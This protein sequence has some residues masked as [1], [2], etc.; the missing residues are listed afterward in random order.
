MNGL[1]MP[2]V[3]APGTGLA[4][5]YS[6]G[7]SG[8][9]SVCADVAEQP[10]QPRELALVDADRG[11]EEDQPHGALVEQAGHRLEQRVEALELAQRDQGTPVGGVLPR[12]GADVGQGDPGAGRLCRHAETVT[13]APEIAR[14]LR[15]V[16]PCAGACH[17][18]CV[19]VAAG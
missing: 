17:D 15:Q 18:A 4:T 16:S 8:A 13:L 7:S 10:V 19:V 1:F 11:A 6:S 5:T 3:S 9:S 12:A 14:Q 2:I